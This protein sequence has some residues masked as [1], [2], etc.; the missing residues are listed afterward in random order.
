[1][2]SSLDKLVPLFDGTNWREWEVCMTAYLQMQELWEVV[3]TNTKPV[4]P[5][6]TE[7]VE[8]RTGSDGT[9]TR[10][11]VRVPPTADEVAAYNANFKDWNKE[12]Q[13]ALGAITLRLSAQLRHHRTDSAF[14]T[15]RDLA[16]QF[17]ASSVSAQ[18]ADFK[19]VLALKLS[20]GNPVPEIERLATLFGR[21]DQSPLE[22][23][24]TLQAMILLAAIP[25]KWDSVAQMYLQRPNLATALT[26][27]NVRAAILQEYE[28]HGRPVDRSGAHK[29]SAVKRKGPDPSYRPQQQQQQ[30]GTSQQHQRQQQGDK[31][32]RRG[33]RQEK[34]KQ[35]RRARKQNDNHHDHSH[36]ASSARIEEIVEPTKAPIS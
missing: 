24:D 19:S 29:L 34:E 36:F 12:N 32:K 13:K 7:G 5:R 18:F 16:A 14:T 17:G 28:R 9:E 31:K 25:Q 30:P 8:T 20:G 26:F 22:L 21:L 27:A 6:P 11:R 10:H 4:E 35:E 15:W 33:G 3:S 23:T 2:T 1:M